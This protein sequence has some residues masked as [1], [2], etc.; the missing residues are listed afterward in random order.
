MATLSTDQTSNAMAFRARRQTLPVVAQIVFWGSA[1][2]VVL[3]FMAGPARLAVATA[4]AFL[5]IYTFW[6]LQVD[7]RDT[8]TIDEASI[9]VRRGEQL[10]GL[11]RRD[12]LVSVRVSAPFPTRRAAGS[13]RVEMKDAFDGQAN[14]R[15]RYFGGHKEWSDVLVADLARCHVDIDRH[16]A[17]ALKHNRAKPGTLVTWQ[18]P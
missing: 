6:A 10:A 14:I 9:A 15:L 7:V 17:Y 8:L 1:I 12:A 5:A 13:I 11:V 2:G 16:T 18:A 3:A 4:L